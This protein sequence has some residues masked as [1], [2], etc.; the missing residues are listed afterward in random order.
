MARADCWSK[1]IN[2]LLIDFSSLSSHEFQPKNQAIKRST[3]NAF[4]GFCKSLVLVA[5]VADGAG[6]V[7]DEAAADV[8]RGDRGAQ[9][10]EEV[11]LVSKLC[12]HVIRWRRP[13]QRHG[14]HRVRNV[15]RVARGERRV[16]RQVPRALQP[17]PAAGGGQVVCVRRGGPH[18]NVQPQ[19]CPQ[20]LRA[21]V[22]GLLRSESATTG[23]RGEE[24]GLWRAGIVRF[25]DSRRFYRGLN[26]H[27]NGS[28]ASVVPVFFTRW[29]AADLCVT[30]MQPSPLVEVGRVAA[31]HST[32]CSRGY[33]C[34]NSLLLVEKRFKTY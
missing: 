14:L 32:D 22:G 10:A 2:D 3:L 7:T 28:D 34:S 20:G 24:R 23:A 5:D 1:L 21:E 9:V 12:A 13:R 19:M 26:E 16:S 4:F 11:L 17:V 18:G 15:T 33:E 27:G 29:I 8:E 25:R 6:F 30:R 31:C